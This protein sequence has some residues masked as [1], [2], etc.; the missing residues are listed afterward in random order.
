M[1]TAFVNGKEVQYEDDKYKSFQ[2]FYD[3]NKLSNKVLSSLSINGKEVPVSKL[4]EILTATFEGGERVEMIF[5]EL[6]PFT[7]KL[8]E[9]LMVYFDK[10]EK[11]IPVF[12]RN[13][14]TGDVNAVDG[15]RNLQE[16]LKAME[17]MKTNLFA[18]TGTQESDFSELEDDKM[19]LQSALN[20][21]NVAISNKSWEELSQLLE[22]DLVE[23]LSYYKDLF[24][25]SSNIL[26]QK[27]S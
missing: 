19:A 16:G 15:L 17:V 25:I 23:A 24:D 2:E 5:E 1:I 18:L 22:Y 9:N 6:I 20:E 11:A 10:F 8:I 26:K 21:I 3:E 13:I 27:K 12:A 14:K 4:D 7:L